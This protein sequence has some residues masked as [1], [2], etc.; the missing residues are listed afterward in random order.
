MKAKILFWRRI[1][2]WI[3]RQQG[4]CPTVFE[5]LPQLLLTALS[6]LQPRF[7]RPL[8]LYPVRYPTP[9]KLFRCLGSTKK[10]FEENF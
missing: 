3:K 8:A 6:K 9:P 1:L 7:A 4:R 5:V 2:L 10:L